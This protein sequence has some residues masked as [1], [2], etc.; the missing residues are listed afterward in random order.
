[1]TKKSE[2]LQKEFLSAFKH[3]TN[4]GG[5]SH[6]FP[7]DMKPGPKPKPKPNIA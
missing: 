1:M 2:N 6:H 7:K 5:W 3:P 4:P